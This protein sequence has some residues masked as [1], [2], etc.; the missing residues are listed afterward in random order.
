MGTLLRDGYVSKGCV[1]INT[2]WAL[3]YGMD[4][5]VRDVYTLVRD[6]YVS[7]GWIHE[8]RMDML[9]YMGWIC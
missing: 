4:M 5:L 1:Y 3:Y 8:Y 2:G 6:G 9:V 7:T